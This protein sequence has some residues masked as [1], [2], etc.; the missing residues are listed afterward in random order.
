MKLDWY[1]HNRNKITWNIK[2]INLLDNT[3]QPSKCR[4]SRLGWKKW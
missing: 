4:K 2:S 3:T 1:E